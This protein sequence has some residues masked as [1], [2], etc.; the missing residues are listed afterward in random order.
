LVKKVL[1]PL[2]ILL[3]INKFSDLRFRDIFRLV[4]QYEHIFEVGL[5]GSFGS[6]SWVADN[7]R[8]VKQ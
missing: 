6:L 1:G 2:G 5:P 7:L 4:E 3:E 8:S